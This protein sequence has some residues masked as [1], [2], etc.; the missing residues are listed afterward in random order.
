VCVCVYSNKLFNLAL[1][2]LL[3]SEQMIKADRRVE[4]FAFNLFENKF[5]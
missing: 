2:Q 5:S 3:V 1:K 4:T